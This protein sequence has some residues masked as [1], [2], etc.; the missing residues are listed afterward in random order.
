[1]IADQEN[2]DDEKT[3]QHS[4]ASRVRRT[5]DPQGSR[6]H[7][8]QFCAKTYLSYPALYTHLRNKHPKGADGGPGGAGGHGQSHGGGGQQ[9]GVGANRG[10]GRPKKSP[11]S[12]A[13]GLGH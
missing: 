12:T 3:F 8:C 5:K 7:K 10:R 1:M 4:G 2:D 13:F 9:P 11:I 6:D